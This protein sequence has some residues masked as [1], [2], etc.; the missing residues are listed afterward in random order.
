MEQIR[1]FIAIELPEPVK[2]GLKQIQDSLK[3]AD[4]SVARWV[5]PQGIHL[6][7][8]FL[9]NVDVDKIDAITRAMQPAKMSVGAF[10]LQIADL[11]VFPN[12]RRVQIVWIGL[13]GSVDKLLELQKDIELYI[14]PLGFPPEKR[15]FTPHLTIARVREYATPVQRQALGEIVAKT[16]TELNLGIK[17]NSISLMRSQ[18]TPKGAIYTRLCSAQLKS[19]CQ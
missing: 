6:T 17:V 10:D 9:G 12:S 1:L 3:S 18:L 15:P 2:T 13:G 5:D 14:A 8:K 16:Q 7:L 19:P 11:G 4:P